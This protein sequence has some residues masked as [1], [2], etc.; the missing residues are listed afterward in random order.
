MVGPLGFDMLFF[1]NGQAGGYAQF[2]ARVNRLANVLNHL[3]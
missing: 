3:G 1:G 2:N